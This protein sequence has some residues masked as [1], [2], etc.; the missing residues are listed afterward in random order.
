MDGVEIIKQP[1]L[2]GGISKQPAHLRQPNQCDDASNVSFDA[3]C[4]AYKRPGSQFLAYLGNVRIIIASESGT[5][6]AAGDAVTQDTNSA[7]GTVIARNGTSLTILQTSV[8]NFVPTTA[9][10]TIQKS[11]G[12]ANISEV[13]SLY[14]TGLELRMYPVVQAVGQNFLAVYAGGASGQCPR[15]IPVVIGNLEAQM[16]CSSA[17]YTYLANGTPAASDFRVCPAASYTFIANSK[18]ALGS[19]GSTTTLA[20]DATKMPHTLTCTSTATPAFSV[21]AP[22][23]TVLGGGD[24]AGQSVPYIFSNTETLYIADIAIHKDRLQIAAGP[25]LTYSQVGNY[26]DFFR[27]KNLQVIDSDPIGINMPGPGST[28]AARTVPFRQATVIFAATQRQFEVSTS[29]TFSPGKV[30]ITPTTDY[31]FINIYPASFATSIIFASQRRETGVIQQ[32]IYDDLQVSSVALELTPHVDGLISPNITRIAT[33]ASSNSIFVLTS[34]YATTIYV[35]NEQHV[36]NKR[37][38]TAWSKWTFS[39]LLRICDICVLNGV[40]Y[41]LGEVSSGLGYV[42]EGILLGT[43]LTIGTGTVAPSEGSSSIT[44]GT[45]EITEYA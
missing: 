27:N 4:G 38:Q 44:G 12:S 15:L 32:Y 43:T 41:I 13:Q 2:F 25:Y 34:D 20:P 39:H 8:G 17:A 31:D 30:A 1:V 10:H 29:D 3:S 40:L 36:G 18:V 21:A 11:G 26:Y 24:R 45:G 33:H 5:P 28:P 6:F 35:Y 37:I 7:T 19:T 42:I 16:T 9:S 22:T 14:T 23:W